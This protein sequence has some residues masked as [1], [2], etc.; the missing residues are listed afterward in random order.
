MRP[1]IDWQDLCL[2]VAR[3]EPWAWVG[4]L[5]E[6]VGLVMRSRGPECAVGSVCRVEPVTAPAFLAEVVGFRRD[7]V[8]LMPYGE[9]RGCNPGSR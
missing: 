9:A 1:G 7:Q 3:T 4:R 5:E 6:L 8:L 2:R